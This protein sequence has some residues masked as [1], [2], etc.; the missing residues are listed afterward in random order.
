M[1]KRRVPLIAGNWKMNGVKKDAHSLAGSLATRMNGMK[2]PKFEMLLCPPA[3]LLAPVADAIRGKGIAVGGQDCHCQPRE[4]P[5]VGF[6]R[7]EE[8]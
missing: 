4:D 3:P 8:A 2:K 5:L 7:G 6:R 1:A